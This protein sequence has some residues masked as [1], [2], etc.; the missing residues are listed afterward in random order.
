[1]GI[2]KHLRWNCPVKN[3]TM[4][5]QKVEYFIGS[6]AVDCLL[7]SKWASGKG[8]AEILFTDRASVVAYLQRLLELEFFYRV[9][10][11]KKKKGEG[12]EKEKGKGKEKEKEKEKEKDSEKGKEKKKKKKKKKEAEV[13]KEPEKAKEETDGKKSK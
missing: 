4:M 3:S 7:D 11:I 8:G 10:R 6:K 2:G 9:H 1:M 5:G 12:K 13:E